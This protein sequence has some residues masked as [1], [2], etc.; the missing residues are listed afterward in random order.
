[1]KNDIDRATHVVLDACAD[2]ERAIRETSQPYEA[3]QISQRLRS[4]IRVLETTDLQAINRS[5]RLCGLEEW[6]A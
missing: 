5:Y 6:T 4:V 1:M 2:F 3:L